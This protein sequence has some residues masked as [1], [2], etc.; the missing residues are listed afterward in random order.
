LDPSLAIGEV[1]VDSSPA[2]AWGEL[3]YRRGSIHTADAIVATPAEKAE[4]F[5]RTGAV[6]VEMEGQCVR[7]LSN[8]LGLPLLSLRAISDIAHEALDPA[9]VGFMDEFGEPRPAAVVAAMVRRP[10][11]IGSTLRLARNAR[12]AADSLTAA[13]RFLGEK[14]LLRPMTGVR[15]SHPDGGF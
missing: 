10:R 2:D 12:R 14:N 3:P 1:V 6:A 4:L 5:R 11:L 8:L 13:I 7:K 15:A 9:V